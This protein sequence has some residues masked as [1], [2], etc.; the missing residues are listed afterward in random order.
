MLAKH[1][2][3]MARHGIIA[4]EVRT[5]ADILAAEQE[6]FEKVWYIRKL[7]LE[8]KIERG[9]SDPLAPEIAE[10]ANAAYGLDNV[11]PWD[12][13]EWVYV[14]GKLSALRWVLGAEWDFLDT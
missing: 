12:D 7:I 13:W 14:N 10:Q 1:P 2:D 9:E 8:E 4:E 3:L 6:Y 5:L 11:G